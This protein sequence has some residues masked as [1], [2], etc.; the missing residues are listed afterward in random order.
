MLRIKGFAA[1]AGKPMRLAVQGVGAR[2]RI[3][4]DRPW[5]AA[6]A[7]QGQIVVIGQT[8]L[9]R[10]AIASAHPGLIGLTPCI[11]WFARR[12]HWTRRR[13]RSI[14]AS[15]RPISYSCPSPTATSAPRPRPGRRTR[16]AAVAAARQPRQAQ[17]S[18]VRRPLRRAGH[19][20]RALHR[21]PPARRP[22]LLALRRRG[23]RARRARE[24]HSARA[25]ARRWPRRCAA[26]EALHRER[27]RCSPAST[28]SS[29]MAARPTPRTRFSS[30]PISPASRRITASPPRPLPMHGVHA[31]GLDGAARAAA[32]GDRV[33]PRLSARRRPRADRGSG[34]GARH[35]GPQCARA[36]C[37]QPQGSR[38]RRLRRIAACATGPRRSSSTPPPFPRVSTTRRRPWRPPACRCSSSSMPARAAKPGS[39]PR[40]ACR[41]PTSPC[42]WCCPSSTAGC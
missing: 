9:D 36:L 33:L 31:L 35:G 11:F 13:P 10:D 25:A 16:R 20:R 1:V 17:A 22:R 7:R 39:N 3:A 34:A 26:G 15:R 4:F 37:R 21:H 23:G 40:A 8:G 27:R 41:K 2:F 19:R 32:R 28:A 14:S 29:P 42:R 24:W 18:D 5:P 30:W 12:G 6:A 38:H